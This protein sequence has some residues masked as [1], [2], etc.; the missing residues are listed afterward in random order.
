MRAICSVTLCLALGMLVVAGAAGCDEG[1][2]EACPT[3]P[4]SGDSLCQNAEGAYY[5]EFS[6]SS[7]DCG[8]PDMLEG[9]VRVDVAGIVAG[10]DENDEPI[11]NIEI[12][13]TDEHGNNT[14]FLGT[15]CDKEQDKAPFLYRFT[16]FYEETLEIEGLQISNQLSGD[17]YDENGDT[18]PESLSGT[19]TVSLLNVNMP[20][21][22]CGMQS[23][24]ETT[25]D[26]L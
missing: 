24:L 22:T 17:F 7:G 4:N 14:R 10:V 12:T 9:N 16:V 3:D 13:L 25:P 23:H 2:C 6:N 11:T 15:M 26:E 5:G 19:Y 1:T 20:E 8:N 21:N 18:I